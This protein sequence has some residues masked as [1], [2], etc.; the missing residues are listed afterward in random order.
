MTLYG[1]TP[2]LTPSYVSDN[3]NVK[4]SSDECRLVREPYASCAVGGW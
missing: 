2:P 1:K 3:P 4:V